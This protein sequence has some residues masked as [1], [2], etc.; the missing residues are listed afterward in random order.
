MDGV[1]DP[2][3]PGPPIRRHSPLEVGTTRPVEHAIDQVVL[4]VRPLTSDMRIRRRSRMSPSIFAP[5][6]SSHHGPNICLYV[7]GRGFA[8]RANQSF[9]C[10]APARKIFRLTRRANQ[11]YNSR[12][13]VPTRG[14]LRGRHGRWARDAMD[15]AASGLR[16]ANQTNDADA[17]GEVVWS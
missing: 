1:F 4:R 12:R 10:P 17:D 15:A 3:S 2:V 6:R 13:L 9:G 7:P 8:R 16:I 14:A 5:V 11:L